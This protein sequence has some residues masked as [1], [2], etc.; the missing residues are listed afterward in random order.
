MSSAG[1]G[2]RS[3]GLVSTLC[4]KKVIK[5][6]IHHFLSGSFKSGRALCED[7]HTRLSSRAVAVRSRCCQA[8]FPH[9][10]TEFLMNAAINN[11]DALTLISSPL[12]GPPVADAVQDVFG[13]MQAH[14]SRSNR[15]FSPGMLSKC[16]KTGAFLRSACAGTGVRSVRPP[17]HQGRKMAGSFVAA[18]T[19]QIPSSAD[20]AV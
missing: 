18:P 5:L 17:V 9:P 7:V 4:I 1:F 10:R 8:T 3:K 2:S 19:A 12:V 15:V 6:Q 13:Y 16:W 20:D 11:N 14:S